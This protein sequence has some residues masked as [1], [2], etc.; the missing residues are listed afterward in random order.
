MAD[1]EKRASGKGRAAGLAAAHAAF[2][3]GDIARTITDYHA[4]NGGWLSMEDMGAFRA[5]VEP[6]TKVRFQNMDV[7]TCGPWCQ[8]PALAMI[9]KHARARRHRA[10]SATTRRPTFIC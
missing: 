3:Q 6:P 10:L 5:R 1:E 7:F 8:G 4:K 2:Y 9:L